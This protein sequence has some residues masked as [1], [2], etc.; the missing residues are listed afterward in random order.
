MQELNLP[1]KEHVAIVVEAM[2]KAHF[3]YGYTRWPRDRYL[4]VVFWAGF[5]AAYLQQDKQS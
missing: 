1:S 4:E 3:S 5:F 2:R